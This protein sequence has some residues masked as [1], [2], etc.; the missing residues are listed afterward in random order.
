M[1]FQTDPARTEIATRLC[2]ALLQRPLSGSVVEFQTGIA[3]IPAA[4]VRMADKLIEE[5]EDPT[6]ETNRGEAPTD[7]DA[8]LRKPF[9]EFVSFAATCQQTN[10]QVWMRTM[11]NKLNE[12][13]AN[14][15]QDSR[16]ELRHDKRFV[17]QRPDETER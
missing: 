14:L 11:L 4:A 13:A 15:E 17:L 10:T 1:T 5:L 3:S 8:E 12:A 7:N 9:V 16:F 6:R 2:A